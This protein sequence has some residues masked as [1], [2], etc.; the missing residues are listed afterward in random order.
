MILMEIEQRL[1]KS[2]SLKK[3]ILTT[4]VVSILIP[5]VILTIVLILMLTSNI[6]EFIGMGY[7][8]IE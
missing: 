5:F 6:D 3:R 1:V 8:S 7:S 4:M 2:K